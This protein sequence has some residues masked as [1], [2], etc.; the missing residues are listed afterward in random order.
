M[1]AIIRYTL[2]TALR[3]WLFIGL[4]LFIIVSVSVSVFLGS[5]AL[6]EQHQMT[7]SYVAGSTR[8]ILILGL[9]LFVCF[10][11]RRSFE[12]REIELIL[13]RPISRTS[14]VLSYW[15]GFAVLAVT[16][17]IP[18]LTVIAF[19]KPEGAGLLY[20]GTSVLAESAIIVAFALVSSLILTSAVSAV[21]ATLAFYLLSRMMGFFVATITLPTQVV[22]LRLEQWMEMVLKGVSIILPRLDLY[23]KSAWLIYGVDKIEAL[24]VYQVQSLIYIPLLLAMAIFDFKRKQF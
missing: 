18:I 2:L 9:V 15:T 23:G 8:L 14:F 5:T 1:L 22:G 12:N 7:L 13:S 20:W 19:L 17:I 4:L 21:L 6:V 16:L 3:D 10:H 24:W 11:V